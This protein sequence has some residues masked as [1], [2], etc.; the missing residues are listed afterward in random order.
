MLIIFLI[1]LFS[2]KLFKCIK[3][4]FNTSNDIEEKI[5]RIIKYDKNNQHIT[6]I[7]DIFYILC[8]SYK[9]N[10][11]NVSIDYVS[12]INDTLNKLNRIRTVK[13]LIQNGYLQFINDEKS[14]RSKYSLY[15]TIKG[16]KLIEFNS[17]FFIGNF[18]KVRYE[19]V[20]KFLL[21]L[22]LSTFKMKINVKMPVIDSDLSIETE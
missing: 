3:R 9:K 20:I 11:R 13:I 21:K 19:W 15:L 6:T 2:T 18:S 10:L 4:W 17:I 1:L 14:I 12:M 22:K 16:I 7:D 8:Y 5:K